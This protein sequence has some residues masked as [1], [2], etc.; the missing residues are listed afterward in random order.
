MPGI[1]VQGTEDM[2]KAYLAEADALVPIEEPDISDSL[3]SYIMSAFNEAR[4]ARETGDVND[5]MMEG[6]RSFNGNY[7]AAEHQQ[8]EEEG[9]SAIFVNLT[10]TKCRVAS[11]WI[12][13][14]L[15]NEDT[16]SIEPT[17]IPELPRSVAENI[18]KAVEEE[19]QKSLET[20]VEEEKAPQ[21]Q[22]EGPPQNQGAPQEQPKPKQDTLKTIKEINE[23]K[24]D[25]ADAILEEINSEAK[26]AFKHTEL[27]I[28]DQM[29]EGDWTKALSEFI[30]DFCIF[31]TA[32]LKG[33][34]VS[35]VPK[36]VW[37]DG[38]PVIT[39]EYTFIN[40]RVSPLDIYPSREATCVNDG[41]FIEHLRLSRSELVA[42]RKI[43]GPYDAEKITKVLEQDDG[44][45]LPNLDESIEQE[46]ADEEL[47]D[48]QVVSNKNVYHG[49]HFFGAVEV[50]L[51]KLWGL[52]L[53]MDD[54]D[55]VEVEAILVGSQVIKA[56]LNKDPLKRRPY[57][58]ASYQNRPGAFWGTS[59]PYS[60][61]DIQRIVNA[62]SRALMNNM[63]LS[64]GP[65]AEI[66]V[67]RLADDGDIEEIRARKIWQ[68]TSDPMGAGGRAVNFFTVP[69]NAGELLKVYEFYEAK[70]DE[71]TMIPKWAYGNEKVG[72]AAQTA[73]GLS[74]LLETASKGIKECI[75]HIDFGV[76]IPRIKYEFYHLML[77]GKIKFTGDINVVARGSK[78]LTNKASEALKRQEFLR[79]ITMPAV[80]ELVGKEGVSNLIR[81]MG[82]EM[83]FVSNIVPSRHELKLK[84]KDEAEQAQ[85]MQQAQA[86]AQIAPTKVQIEGQERMHKGTLELKAAE[87]TSKREL[88]EAKL[89][90]KAMAEDLRNQSNINRDQTTLAKA[91]MET[92]Q[93]REATSKSI[94]LSIQ[95]GHED[96]SQ[97]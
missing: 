56:V 29:I 45:G 25:M 27:A 58:S 15:L 77:S 91:G 71:V 8:I 97:Q 55:I 90:I 33:P 94:A 59:L 40:K 89:Q 7:S 69:S 2:V 74:M 73:T 32:I 13:D 67:D 43:G 62:T 42:L 11:S 80:L 65:Q 31:P 86:E 22:A 18:T 92:E 49:L 84:E 96:K 28:R 9:G 79:I 48:N 37:R 68:V 39:D 17:P 60:I 54:E 10:S 70:A 1:E 87:M 6:L 83:G 19:F 34:I 24:R 47:R 64:S 95:S 76:I 23:F 46:K 12:K 14:I 85:A 72:G 21:E 38:E 93:K 52:E 26:Y 61:R 82:S 53:G 78:A 3:H 41:N 36:L 4:D 30:D 57:Y 88:E 35:M 44:K 51:L 16:I 81:E 5:L 66:Y 75:R 63:A 20:E 50:K